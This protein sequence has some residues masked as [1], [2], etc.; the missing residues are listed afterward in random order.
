MILEKK[1]IAIFFGGKSSEHEISLISKKYIEEQILGNGKLS[2]HTNLIEIF[3]SKDGKFLNKNHRPITIDFQ[4]NYLDGELSKPLPIHYAIPVIHGFP[5]ET[6]DLPSFFELLQIPFLG[7]GSEASKMCFNKI[8]SKLWFTSLGIP[9]TPY[10]FLNSQ[11]RNDEQLG[12]DFFNAQGKDLYMKA[13][14]QGSS[15]GCYHIRSEEEFRKYLPMA[16]QLSDRVLLE[17]TIYGRELEISSFTFQ[18]KLHLSVPGE[19]KTPNG[20]YTYEEKYQKD[21]K[22]Q[23]S[24]VADNV[25]KAIVEEIRRI[26]EKAFLGLKL[27][28]LSRIDFFYDEK[29]QKIYLNEIN[30]FPGM[31]PISMFPKMMEN[32]GVKFSDFIC[33]KILEGIGLSS[34]SH[35]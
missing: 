28:D 32:Y 24:I 18:G 27:K 26:G 23:T 15:I 13:S 4:G 17:Q 1:N 33:E 19:I 14:N 11:S 22:T 10:L 25:P 20:F 35:Q 21:S 29:N 5:G 16:F 30:T 6:G 7:V 2:T 31:T 12:L 3:I 34:Q 9:N 8:T